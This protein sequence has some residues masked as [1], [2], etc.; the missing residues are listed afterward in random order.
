MVGET[1]EPKF[2]LDTEGSKWR[3]LAD[4]GLADGELVAGSGL[5]M[6]I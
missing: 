1:V 2:S 5:E 4:G 6:P 3:G